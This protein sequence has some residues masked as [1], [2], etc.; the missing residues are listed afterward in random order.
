MIE[1]ARVFRFRRLAAA[2]LFPVI[3]S[4]PVASPALA[5]DAG[6]AGE[7]TYEEIQKM[8][9]GLEARVGGMGETVPP[10][11]L[12]TLEKQVEEAVRLLTN[13][14][15]ENL[16]LRD[17]A[18]G[19]ST[20]LESVAADHAAL[21]DKIT[22]IEKERDQRVAALE[23]RATDA[24]SALAEARAVNDEKEEELDRL[25]KQLEAVVGELARLNAEL[26]KTE[27]EK[28][29]QQERIA[30]LDGK[31]AKALASRV[32][33]MAR[34]RSEFFGKLREVLGE[35]QDIRIVGDRFVFQSEVLFGSGEAVLGDAGKTR[36]E[37]FADTLAT[38]AQTIPAD[39]DWVLR[40]DG[41]TDRI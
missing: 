3:V 7:G 24:E 37:S 4:A 25:G 6:A 38:V 9:D 26:E 11:T 15:E 18:T 2:A 16:L 30:E 13:R 39:I 32:E 17:K 14:S 40:V 23:S 8:I 5:Q 35:R 20:E 10:E 19:L 34:Y 22:D 21:S 36:L 12:E 41:H 31:L 33:E 29:E 27:S 28:A 1:V